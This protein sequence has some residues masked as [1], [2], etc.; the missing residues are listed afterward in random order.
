MNIGHREEAKETQ[1]AANMRLHVPGSRIK[2]RR[3]EAYVIM[4]NLFVNLR[5]FWVI[6]VDDIR[7]SRSERNTGI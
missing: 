2:K 6:R 3:K 5:C 1:Y 7:Q 4:M